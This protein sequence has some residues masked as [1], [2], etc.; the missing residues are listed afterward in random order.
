MPVR[1]STRSGSCDTIFGRFVTGRWPRLV[2]NPEEERDD[3]ERVAGVAVEYRARAHVMRWLLAAVALILA[4]ACTGG[5]RPAPVLP[6]VSVPTPA[7][8]LPPVS[9]PT[10]APVPTPGP[11]AIPAAVAS[12]V[13]QIESLFE[14]GVISRQAADIHICNL[15]GGADCAPPGSE[16]DI[17]PT[18]LPPLVYDRIVEPDPV[19]IAT[20]PVILGV[21]RHDYATATT[22]SRRI[23]ELDDG[24]FHAVWWDGARIVGRSATDGRTFGPAIRLNNIAAATGVS[25]A[26]DGDT[27]HIVYA[28]AQGVCAFGRS[29]PDLLHLDERQTMYCSETLLTVQWPSVAIAPDGFPWIV[30]RSNIVVDGQE[31]FPVFVLPSDSSGWSQPLL[32]STAEQQATSG[33]GS[34]GAVF[35][36]G[37]RAL[38]LHT[39][40]ALYSSTIDGQHQTVAS[41]YIGDGTHGFSGVVIGER[42]YV[43]YT[44]V[45]F[46]VAL[47]TFTWTEGWSEP[48]PL[49]SA[50][51][52]SLGLIDVAGEP[53][54]VGYDGERLWWYTDG[55]VHSGPELTLTSSIMYLATPERARGITM[56]WQDGVRP[57]IG[58]VG[59]I[60]IVST[61]VTAD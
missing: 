52:R 55:V 13:A 60:Y 44:T 58:E 3:P 30:F 46:G 16:I 34:T 35:F 61:R 56:M 42:L 15:L 10:P 2:C 31:T 4:A 59:A 8:V 45:S 48:A 29:G 32:I 38:I 7:S 14:R 26:A 54:V 36:P 37:G 21:V 19:T 6:P 1:L 22:S 49:P 43:A 5:D 39:G 33:V 53:I 20:E 57:G 24:S 27:L 40:R 47:R 18:P 17:S 50:Y 12:A 28:D 41:D 23:V 11:T 51:Q 25:M 9:V